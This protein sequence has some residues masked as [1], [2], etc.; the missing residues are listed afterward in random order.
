ME[1]LLL[2]SEELEEE[3]A[4]FEEDNEEFEGKYE[5]FEDRFETLEWLIR[6]ECDGLSCGSFSAGNGPYCPTRNNRE[7]NIISWF[8]T[9]SNTQ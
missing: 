7:T 5:E 6:L 2:G 9:N 4:E 8:K 1:E 3:S